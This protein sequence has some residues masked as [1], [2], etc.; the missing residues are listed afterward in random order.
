M[1]GTVAKQ[2]REIPSLASGASTPAPPF[3]K[4]QASQNWSENNE[5]LGECWNCGQMGH[6]RFQCPQPSA[7]RPRVSF[8]DPN[9]SR[10]SSD[11]RRSVSPT[12][13]QS[14]WYSQGSDSARGSQQRFAGGKGQSTG[15]FQPAHFQAGKGQGRGENGGKSHY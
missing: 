14:S 13:P 8:S 1:G 12:S 2:P 15:N 5:F 6:R 10:S 11:G 3:L 7:P 4:A 9:A